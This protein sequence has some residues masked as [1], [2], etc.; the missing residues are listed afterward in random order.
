MNKNAILEYLLLGLVILTACS[1]LLP[2]YA[3]YCWIGTVVLS[4]GVVGLLCS[5]IIENRHT[6]VQ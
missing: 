5:V 2:A 4:I 1:I 6:A 3:I